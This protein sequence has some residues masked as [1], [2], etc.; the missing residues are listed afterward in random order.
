MLDFWGVCYF[1]LGV[2][3]QSI[4]A[5]A[6]ALLSMSSS[7]AAEV[8]WWVGNHVTEIPGDSRGLS[9]VIWFEGGRFE[10]PS[11]PISG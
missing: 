10:T 4:E 7:E 9:Y 5:F 8:P 1:S 2:H 3:L 11:G 6:S